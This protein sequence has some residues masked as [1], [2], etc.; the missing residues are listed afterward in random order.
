MRLRAKDQ[1][2]VSAA[3][4][5]ALRPGQEF[6]ISDAQGRE[7]MKAHPS[8]FE[9]VGDDPGAAAAKA[10]ANPQNKA[11]SVPANKAATRRKGDDAPTTKGSAK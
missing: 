1:V 10:E 7:L 9:R 8:L 11:E 6:E 5:D 2:H 4:A 3:Q